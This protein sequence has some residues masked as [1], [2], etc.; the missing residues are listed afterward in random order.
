M[1]PKIFV[2]AA[3][4]PSSVP[5]APAH[6]MGPVTLLPQARGKRTAGLLLT[7]LVHLLII[8]G[9]WLYR[10]PQ[11]V[12]GD[13]KRTVTVSLMPLAEEAA[14]ASA[15]PA[16]PKPKPVPRP[17]PPQRPPE[18]A[19]RPRSTTPPAIVVPPPEYLPPQV[20]PAPI[21]VE[22]PVDLMAMVNKKRQEREAAAPAS[23]PSAPASEPSANDV[24]MANINRNLQTLAG[25]RP[26]TSDV[27][28]ILSKGQ[29]EARFSFRGWTPGIGNNWREVV[30][31]DAGLNGNIELAIVRKMIEMIRT[32]YKGDFNWDSHR[33][34]RIVVL[35]ARPEDN[36]GLEAFLMREFFEVRR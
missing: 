18:V 36:A 26:G 28:E 7:V 22:P 19:Q 20:P 2:T 6:A 25:G 3:R 5:A 13:A 17:T 8:V 15:K 16:L 21:N 34:G 1:P 29:R 27:F 14:P 9:L 10:T 11:K 32:H 4:A 30:E 31:V 33:L 12:P 24:A 35:S 23:P